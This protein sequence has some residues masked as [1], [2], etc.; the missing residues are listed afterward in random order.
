LMLFWSTLPWQED[1]RP[2]LSGRS[3]LQ[4]LPAALIC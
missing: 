3:A 2:A 1:E 4:Y